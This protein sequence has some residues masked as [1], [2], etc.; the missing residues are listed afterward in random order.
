MG[1]TKEWEKLKDKVN[2]EYKKVEHGTKKLTNHVEKGLKKIEG[3]IENNFKDNKKSTDNFISNAIKIEILKKQ[4]Q[5]NEDDKNSYNDAKVKNNF[6][7]EKFQSFEGDYKLVLKALDERGQ[8]L[9]NCLQNKEVKATCF[10]T[11][12]LIKTDYT[13]ILNLIGENG[14]EL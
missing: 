1:F 8:I 2:K 11:V 4:Q 13:D 10:D 14:G 12:E 5:L 9:S 7:K 3:H 6:I